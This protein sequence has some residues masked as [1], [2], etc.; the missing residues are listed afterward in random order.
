MQHE[1]AQFASSRGAGRYNELTAARAE[2]TNA[3]RRYEQIFIGS[4]EVKNE[5]G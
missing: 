4:R 1:C 3:D 5:T 2:D